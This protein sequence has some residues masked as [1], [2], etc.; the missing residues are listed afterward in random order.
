MATNIKLKLDKPVF[1]SVVTFV[2]Y[3]ADSIRVENATTLVAK[4]YLEG[5]SRNLQNREISERRKVTV[6]MPVWVAILFDNQVLGLMRLAGDYECAVAGLL[7]IEV[8]RQIN[9]V[10]QIKMFK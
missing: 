8:E 10:I 1:D 3:A 4:E 5:L 6:S 2:R 7:H 9:R